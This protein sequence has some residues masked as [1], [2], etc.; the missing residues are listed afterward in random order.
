MGSTNTTVVEKEFFPDP[1][2]LKNLLATSSNKD[3]NKL[4][5]PAIDNSDTAKCNR[6]VI[7]SGA[8]DT[9]KEANAKDEILKLIAEN[10]H[11]KIDEIRFKSRGIIL[12]ACKDWVGCKYIADSYNKTNLLGKEIFCTLYSETDPSF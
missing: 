6:T 1:S 2:D 7:V 12:V 9:I 3:P 10:D 8:P 11:D 4:D 5:T